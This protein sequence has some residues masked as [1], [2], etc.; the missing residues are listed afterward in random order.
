M[1]ELQFSGTSHG[2]GYSGKILGLPKG[3]AFSVE[4]INLQLA[5]RKTGFG[6]SSRQTN[7][8]LV[9]FVGENNGVVVCDGNP[10]E[11]AVANK[12]VEQRQEIVA[13]RSGHTDVVGK[14]R[15]PHLTVRQI[16]EI[17]SARN[18]IGYVVA[19]AICKQLLAKHGISTFHY[20]QKIG[21]IASRNR[22]VFG[23]SEEQP[24]FEILHC[25][26]R[27]ATG[28][29]VEKIQQ[30]R[31]NGNSLGG[32]VVVG[33]TG[34][35]MGI[36]EIFPYNKRLDAQIS[37][38]LL[39][40]PS[41]KGISLGIGEKYASL[42]GISACDT[43]EVQNGKIVYSSNKCGGIVGGISTGQ[44]ILCSLVVKPVPTVVGAPSINSKTLEQTTAHY[45]R[46]DTCVVPNV[47]VI[48][49]NILAIVLANQLTKQLTEQQN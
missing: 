47:G 35:P 16:A 2:Q 28:L 17:S 36:G 6:R 24:H 43:L 18:S 4:Q 22:Y 12:C 13:L 42:D 15:F 21:G 49:E 31:Q 45:E 38:E 26:C 19:G 25:P 46:A 8:D 9:T 14:A 41:V 33:A 30:A 7:A 44:D 3:F 11:F 32:V 23:V 39:G 40:I 48:G 29:M 10:V 20:V 1:V 37:A 5:R 27:Y 34:V